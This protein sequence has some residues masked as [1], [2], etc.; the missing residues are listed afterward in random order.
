MDN[1][2]ICS[3]RISES[4]A[5]RLNLSR[6]AICGPGTRVSC[7]VTLIQTEFGSRHI[8]VM[9]KKLVVTLMLA[10]APLAQARAVLVCAM[11]HGQLMERC[12]CEEQ[13]PACPE[14]E[15]AEPNGR[16]CKV[17]MDASGNVGLNSAVELV[18]KNPIQKLWDRSPDLATTPPQAA[19]AV[20][21]AASQASL[22]S[23]SHLQDGTNRYLLT[24]RLRL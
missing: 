15:H 5:C 19:I 4:A 23:Q 8:V 9:F 17:V 18:D 22:L 12:C 11:M 20:L 21:Q 2:T 24:A 16:C 3:C 1:K 10:A 14:C 6:L 13:V 7:G